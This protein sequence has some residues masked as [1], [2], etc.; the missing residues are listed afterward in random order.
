MPLEWWVVLRTAFF[1]ACERLAP[2]AGVG[3][4]LV[5]AT[6]MRRAAEQRIAAGGSV[7][8]GGSSAATDTA[9]RTSTVPST[10]IPLPAPARSAR[11]SVICEPMAKTA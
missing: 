1:G 8:P 9:S 5:L 3:A 10:A 6:E 2:A 4:E 11:L 7:I